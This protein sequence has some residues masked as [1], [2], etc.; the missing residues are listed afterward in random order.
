M[1]HRDSDVPCYF[2]PAFGR[3][4]KL[5]TEYPEAALEVMCGWFCAGHW[6]PQRSLLN[7]EGG[8][9]AVSR[10]ASWRLSGRNDSIEFGVGVCYC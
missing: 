5:G 3:E 9:R 8:N 7:P 4:G 2:L 10:P 6:F 1:W